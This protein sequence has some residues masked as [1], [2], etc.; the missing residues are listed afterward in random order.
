MKTF[1]A[2]VIVSLYLFVAAVATGTI[3]P[4]ALNARYRTPGRV[5]AASTVGLWAVVVLIAAAVTLLCPP[6]AASA[7]WRPP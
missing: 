2:F 7:S 4:F 1:N 6:P 3:T 5:I